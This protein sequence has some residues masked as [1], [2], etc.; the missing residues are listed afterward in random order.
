MELAEVQR[1][2][3]ELS[4]CD[5]ATLAAW[6][7]EQDQMEWEAQMERDFSPGGTGMAL[8]ERMKADARSGDFRP[9]EE[10]PPRDSQS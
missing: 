3:S 1:A 7:A 2:S 8:L 4:P 5:R 6:L 10:G 9:L